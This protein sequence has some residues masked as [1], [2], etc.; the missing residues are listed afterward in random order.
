MRI[1][2]ITL[3]MGF[4]HGAFS[5][6]PNTGYEQTNESSSK[7]N[8]FSPHFAGVDFGIGKFMMDN[9]DNYQYWNTYDLN[10]IQFGLNVIEF[11]LPIAKQ[12]LG[13]TSG[14]GMNFSALLL[15]NYDLVHTSST[16]GG[17]NDTIFAQLNNSTDYRGN[18][19]SYGTLN[20]PLLLEVC[21]KE[22]S[23]NAFYLN[24]GA[25]GYWTMFRTWNRRG[26]LPNGDRFEYTDRSRYQV[27][28]FGAYATL[29]TG[30]DNYG[31]F[32]NYNLT[33]LFKKSATALTY[34]LTFGISWNVDYDDR[35]GETN[36]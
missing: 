12:Y 28:P 22:K 14:L 20:L 30:F 23:K 36:K 17:K 25:V 24:V 29:R 32:I 16:P 34:P 35:I 9:P 13:I 31:L 27:A 7:G 21:T 26:F 33:P 2:I 15:N 11:K 1:L 5:Q 19:L 3:F 10:L 8:A 6:I 4:S 18:N